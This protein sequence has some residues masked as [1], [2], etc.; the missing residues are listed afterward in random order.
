MEALEMRGWRNQSARHSLASRGIRS[1]WPTEKEFLEHHITGCIP[2]DAY[3]QYSTSEGI[4]WLGKPEEYPH[5]L[6]VMDIDGEPV[7]IRVRM[8][9]L[10]YVKKDDDGEIVRDRRGM[11]MYLTDEEAAKKG[12]PLLEPHV[13]AFNSKGQPVGWASNEWGA[14]GVWVVSDYQHKG[15]GYELL[16]EFRKRFPDRRL[17]QA[18][19]A[20]MRLA[21]KYYRKMVEEEG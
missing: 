1:R 20:G 15:I 9:E 17:G 2:S 16:K 12:Y 11:A 7:E 14:T 3:R 18:T 10:Q 19:D 8:T 4:S 5:V 6:K 21:G 13:V